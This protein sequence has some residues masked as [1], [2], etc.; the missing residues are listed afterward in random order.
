MHNLDW[1]P[2]EFEHLSFLV[3]SP[4]HY[5]NVTIG[6]MIQ[7]HMQTLGVENCPLRSADAVAAKRRQ[8]KQNPSWVLSDGSTTISQPPAWYGPAAVREGLHDPWILPQA[9]HYQSTAPVPPQETTIAYTDWNCTQDYDGQ[10]VDRANQTTL[11]A[12]WHSFVVQG[13]PQSAISI[14]NNPQST[15]LEPNQLNLP[16]V[17]G[18]PTFQGSSASDPGC[19]AAPTL[20]FA[21]SSGSEDPFCDV[22]STLYHPLVVCGPVSDFSK[23]NPFY[24]HMDEVEREYG[25]PF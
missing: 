10:A 22:P 12:N 21:P 9:G 11:D 8:L 7:Q 3:A 16:T 23:Q 24:G 18:Y 6:R 15:L 14:R 25:R 4:Q 17:S 1:D 5:P 2:R 20:T 19:A 13:L